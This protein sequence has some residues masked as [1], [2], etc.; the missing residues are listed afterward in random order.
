[1]VQDQVATTDANGT[2][3]VDLPVGI[4]DVLITAPGFTPQAVKGEVLAGETTQ[5][6]VVLKAAPTHL[7]PVEQP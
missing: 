6:V 5:L 2:C 4:Y 1:M 3:T 7:R